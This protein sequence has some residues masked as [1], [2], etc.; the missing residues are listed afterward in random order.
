MELQQSAREEEMELAHP[1][2]QI[3]APKIFQESQFS[4]FLTLI[5]SWEFLFEFTIL[6]IHSPPGWDKEYTFYFLNMLTNKDTYMPVPYFAS[7]FIFALMFLRLY[8]LIRT[9]LNFSLYADLYA[10]KICTKYGFEESI[11]F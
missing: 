10:K 7:D 2:N 11:G 6:A 8:F 1:E 4:K 3:K 9:L 5:F